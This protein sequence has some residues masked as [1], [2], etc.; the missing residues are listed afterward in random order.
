MNTIK[1]LNIRLLKG[2]TNTGVNLQYTVDF[3]KFNQ[4]SN[5][6]I[7]DIIQSNVE[8]L[9]SDICKSLNNTNYGSQLYLKTKKFLFDDLYKA[10]IYVIFFH[11][12]EKVI[13][14]PLFNLSIKG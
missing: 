5:E 14:N 11:K 8:E 1:K 2:I 3:T 13:I 12:D 9:S 7:V 10:L 6:E 4:Y